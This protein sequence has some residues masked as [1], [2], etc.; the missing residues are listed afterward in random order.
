MPIFLHICTLS[1]DGNLFSLMEIVNNGFLCLEQVLT[2]FKL[3]PL[4]PRLITVIPILGLCY[5]Q[6]VF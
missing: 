1:E 5:T 4:L 3:M 2:W 6:K